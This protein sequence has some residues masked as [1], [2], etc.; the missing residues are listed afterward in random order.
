[1]ARINPHRF[2]LSGALETELAVEV[3]SA[4]IGGEHVLMKALVTSH[5][6]AHKLGADAAPVIIG[7]DEKMWVIDD[8]V[9]VG[10]GV[11]EADETLTMPSREKRMRAKQS[12]MQQVWLLCG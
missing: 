8:K 3:E 6:S 12:A 5:K 1:M 11:A 7:M 4:T 10:N 9:A 2:G